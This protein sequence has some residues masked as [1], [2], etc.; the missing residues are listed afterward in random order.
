MAEETALRTIE[1][2]RI[3]RRS[4]LTVVVILAVLLILA[5]VISVGR[6]FSILALIFDHMRR[7]FEELSSV[8]S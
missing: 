4:L 6:F 5:D 8:F 2:H 1:L 7:L 3:T